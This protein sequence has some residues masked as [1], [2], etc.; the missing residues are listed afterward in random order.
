MVARLREIADI[1]AAHGVRVAFETGQESAETL[2]GVLDEL[3]RPGVGVNFDPA[4]MILYG[5]GEPVAAVRRLAPWVRQIHVK[6]AT[7]TLQPGTW[8]AEVPGGTGAVDWT[9]FFEFARAFLPGVGLVIEREAG[10][11]R[12]ADVQAARTLVAKHLSAKE[13]APST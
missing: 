11:N 13:G 10:E 12:V 7:P 1:F 4:N 9:S 3:C 6:D 5:M 2:V 8:G